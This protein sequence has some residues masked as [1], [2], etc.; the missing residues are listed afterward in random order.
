M[1]QPGAA[2]NQPIRPQQ[3]GAFIPAQH[4]APPMVGGAGMLGQVPQGLGVNPAP[5]PGGFRP[6]VQPVMPQQTPM[7]GQF[8]NKG[9][10]N[11][12]QP[13]M[14][15]QPMQ[16]PMQRPLMLGHAPLRA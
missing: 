7:Q 5:M 4:I 6:P 16:P 2:S 15:P 10:N 3:P 11:A 9:G 1:G 13:P 8:G 14:Q 12:I